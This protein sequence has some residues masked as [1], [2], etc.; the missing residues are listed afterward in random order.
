MNEQRVQSDAT[1]VEFQILMKDMESRLADELQKLRLRVERLEGG[2]GGAQEATSPPPGPLG[3]QVR[4]ELELLREKIET[5]AIGTRSKE[6]ELERK[7]VEVIETL[8]ALRSVVE[9]L[10]EQV[11][12]AV[13]VYR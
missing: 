12:V 3:P 13:P 1:E 11:E 2:S 5:L 9:S 6:A 10:A 4:H 8:A 7:I